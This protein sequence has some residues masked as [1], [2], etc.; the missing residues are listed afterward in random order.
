MADKHRSWIIG[1]GLALPVL[2]SGCTSCDGPGLDRCPSIA[3]GAMPPPAGTHVRRLE[4]MQID[5]AEA[6]DFVVYRH[7]W[8]MGGQELGPYGKYHLQLIARRLP[9]VP[10]PVLIEA[11]DD[12]TLNENRRKLVV[13]MLQSQGITDAEQRVV[14]GY[15]EAEGLYG[16]EAEQAFQQMMQGQQNQFGPG[17]IGPLN[18]NRF[19]N[20]NLFRGGLGLGS[21]PF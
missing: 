11:A 1:L 4:T 9:L 21:F 12:M 6:D 16:E 19:N 14:L 8:Y 15:P 7:E 20:R 18:N 5:K 17:N 3:P 10:F 13:Q 2:I